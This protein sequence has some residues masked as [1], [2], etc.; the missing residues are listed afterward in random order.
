MYNIFFIYSSV[1]GHLGC[2][3]IWTIVNSAAKNI[4]YI[5]FNYTLV[6]IYAQASQ[7]AQCLKNLPAIQET[8][9]T[10]V[11][12]LGWEDPLEKSMATHSSILAWRI[13][14]IEQLGGLQ[15]IGLQRVRHN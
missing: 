3:H 2:L 9:E 11:P 4:V 13:P 7:V 1:D 14:W 15:S 12:F 10:Q 8:Q 5:F 6:W